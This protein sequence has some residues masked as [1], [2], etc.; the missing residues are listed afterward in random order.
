MEDRFRIGRIEAFGHV[1]MNQLKDHMQYG[2]SHRATAARLGA[3]TNT[4]IKYARYDQVIQKPCPE[5]SPPSQKSIKV[6]HPRM[7]LA[8]SY[9]RVD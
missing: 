8:S 5:E 6:Q 7:R 4:I 2:L 3:D 9:V 1:W